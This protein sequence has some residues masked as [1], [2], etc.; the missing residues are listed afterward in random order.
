MFRMAILGY[1]DNMPYILTENIRIVYIGRGRKV[2]SG[3][4]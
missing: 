2:Q 3:N 4:L 1:I